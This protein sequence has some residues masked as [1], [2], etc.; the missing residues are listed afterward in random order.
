MAVRLSCSRF[1]A[2]LNCV[3][4]TCHGSIAKSLFIV[5]VIVVHSV[6]FTPLS[7]PGRAAVYNQEVIVTAIKM[8]MDG[9]DKTFWIELAGLETRGQRGFSRQGHRVL[10][11]VEPAGNGRLG[12]LPGDLN[13][14]GCC[15]RVGC[16]ACA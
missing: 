11:S 3:V 15:H 8:L 12:Q 13:Q 16:G 5:V 9:H 2:G 4:V 10:T 6:S 14:A 1:V 7:L